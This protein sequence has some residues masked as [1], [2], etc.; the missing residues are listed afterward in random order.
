MTNLNDQMEFDHVVRVTASGTVED[1]N[2][3]YAPGLFDGN[4]DSVGEGW[5]L[6][7]GFS[8]QDRY[9]GPLMHASELIGGGLE[10]YIRDHPGLYVN[11]VN[12]LPDEGGEPQE[13]DNW[14]VAF[15]PD[16]A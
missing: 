2:D 1:A 8:G 11:L 6:L 12:Y 14:A 5:E 13:P 10:R 9:S 4:L 3:I 7:N 16:S 15:R